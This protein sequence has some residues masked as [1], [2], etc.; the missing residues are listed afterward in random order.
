MTTA[1]FDTLN[2]IH[3]ASPSVVSAS[4][5]ICKSAVFLAERLRS[6]SSTVDTAFMTDAQFDTMVINHFR[7]ARVMDNQMF[8]GKVLAYA[9]YKA[10][11]ITGGGGSGGLYIVSPDGVYAIWVGFGKLALVPLPGGEVIVPNGS[12]AISSD[13]AYV[14]LGTYGMVAI[15]ALDVGDPVLLNT[16]SVVSADGSYVIFGTYGKAPLLDL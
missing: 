8:L 11:G 9:A 1:E 3:N 5:Y 10:D 7:P 15:Q 12:F 6:A 13:P 4:D 14:I 16:Q 2:T